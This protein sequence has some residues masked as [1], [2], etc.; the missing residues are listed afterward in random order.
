MIGSRL[1]NARAR[2]GLSLR[3]LE[4]KIGNLVSA[5]AIGK[6]ERDEMMPGSKVLLAIAD[7]LQVS[8][9]YLLSPSA[10][11]LEEVEFRKNR[12]TNKREEAS[13]EAS[14][15][16]SVER[17]LQVE[18]VLAAPSATW[19]MPG[20]APFRIKTF[21]DA[22]SA[23]HR[24]RQLWEL[25][26]DPL[27]NFSEFLEEKGIKVIA[28]PL[29]AAVSGMMCFVL[30][31]GDGRVPVIVINNQ[32][33]GERQRFTLAHELGHLVLDVDPELDEEKAAHRFG[34]AFLMPQE[35]LR[36]EVGQHRTAISLGELFQLKPLFG[37]SVQAIAYRC[38]DL[39]ILAPKASSYLFATFT[40]NGWRSPP[41]AEPQPIAKEDPGRFK[42]LCFRALAEGLISEAKTA[43]LLETTVHQLNRE[44]DGPRPAS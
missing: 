24:L 33:T 34:G 5:Q 42:R 43:E 28:K 39:G 22:E 30:K 8:E 26:V 15:L 16:S 4:E 31:Q 23:A 44:M 1:K 13:V 37:V 7:A 14:V 19:S 6:Y 21:E 25:G 2:A 17:Y 32:D 40:K 3:E 18:D 36:A 41:Y 38:K 10:I 12:L 11:K 9:S 35:V 27:P 29:E 20:G